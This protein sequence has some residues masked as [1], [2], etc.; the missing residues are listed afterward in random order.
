[1]PTIIVKTNAS[2]EQDTTVTLSENVQPV[3]LAS[4]HHAAQLIQR[5]GW[6][7]TDAKDAEESL[8]SFD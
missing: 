1:M 6:A 3:H 8:R 2:T 4:D 5:L 7:V